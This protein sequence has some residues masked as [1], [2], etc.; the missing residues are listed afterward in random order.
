MAAQSVTQRALA[1]RGDVMPPAWPYFSTTQEPT[2]YRDVTFQI[3]LFRAGDAAVAALLPPPLEPAPAGR[4]GALAAIDVPYAS[5]YGPFQ[6][7]FLLLPCA[8]RGEPAYY[9]PY[10][11]LNNVR[12]ICAGREIWGTP[13]V[14]ADV[15]FERQ[16]ETIHSQTRFEGH[17]LIGMTTTTAEAVRPDDL[18][19]LSPAYRL[20]LIPAADGRSLAVQQ[21]VTGEPLDAQVRD[22]RRGTG[23]LRFGAGA[24]LDLMPLYPQ[25]TLEAFTY[26]TSYRETFG[27]IAW[28]GLKE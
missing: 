11:F 1:G 20:K 6:E 22:V 23:E 18:P 14:Y 16:G 12:A 3:L 15:S 10:V 21:L 27:T 24:G 26:T 5:S 2:V 19:V 8:F 4:P 7:S 9:V 13:K 28:D 25:V 17:D